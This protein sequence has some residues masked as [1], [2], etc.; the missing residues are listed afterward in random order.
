MPVYLFPVTIAKINFKL[1]RSN[2][3]QQ[4]RTPD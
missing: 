4:N 2:L 3:T 1:K